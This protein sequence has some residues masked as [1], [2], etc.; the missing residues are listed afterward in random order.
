MSRPFSLRLSALAVALCSFTTAALAAPPAGIDDYVARAMSAFEAPGMAIAI[1]ED[2]KATLTKGY[3]IRKMGQSARIDEHSLFPMASNTKQFTATALALLVDEGKLSWDDK[4]VSH[5]PG[6]QM[7]DPYV[8]GE[9]NVVDLLTHRSGLGLGQGDLM[10]VGTDFSGREVVERLRHLKPARGFRSGYAYDNVLYV[11]AGQL[12]EAIAKQP[13]EEFIRKRIFAPLAMKDSVPGFKDLE[14]KRNRA[15][16][17]GRRDGAMF[18]VGNIAPLNPAPAVNDA[19]SPTG[20]INSSAADMAKWLAVQLGHGALPSGGRLFSEAQSSALWNPQTLMPVRPAS[21]SLAS[22]EPQFLS[23]ALGY[24]VSDYRGHKI[25]THGG[26]WFGGLSK[27]VLIPDR[28]VGF[29][30]MINSEESGAMRSVE[31]ALLDHYLDQPATDWTPILREDRKS[32]IDKA[33]AAVTAMKVDDKG[34]PPPS[35][36][37]EKYAGAYRDPWYGTAIIRYKSAD[38]SLSISFERTAG[39]DGPLQPVR[40]DTFRTRWSDRSFEDAYVTFTLKPD[41]SIDHAVMK[42]ISPMADFSFDFQDLLFTPV[43]K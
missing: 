31:L 40:H 12:I 22:T 7:Y 21:G 9:M 5:L 13:F 33:L 39:M 32:K 26:G 17:H 27:T 41:G 16:Q 30:V 3:G 1:V 14:R 35:L 20:G 11:A 43:A 37:L 4:V 34:G 38:N 6:F 29:A 25:I 2:G 10:I 36:P 23:Y 15:W 8:T 18:G 28:N 24:V 42:A 19:S